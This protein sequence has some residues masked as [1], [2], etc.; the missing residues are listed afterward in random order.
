MSGVHKMEG[1][2]IA[3][4]QAKEKETEEF[5]INFKEMMDNYK[6]DHSK[7]IPF[8]RS[9]FIYCCK[10]GPSEENEDPSVKT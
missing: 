2:L 3:E 9:E 1:S 8:P 10:I 7:K 5:Q 4:E 6:G